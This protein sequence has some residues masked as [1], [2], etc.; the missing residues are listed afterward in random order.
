MV[1]YIDIDLGCSLFLSLLALRSLPGAV[2]VDC[3]VCGKVLVYNIPSVSRQTE[4]PVIAF[5]LGKSTTYALKF[6]DGKDLGILV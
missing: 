6:P 2:I 4:H 1:I 3:A 5:H